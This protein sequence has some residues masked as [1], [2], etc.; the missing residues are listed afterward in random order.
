MRKSGK[1]SEARRTHAFVGWAKAKRAHHA[2]L[3]QMKMVGTAQERLYPPLYKREA[4][5]WHR[6]V[7]NGP[8]RVAAQ[9][10]PPIDR[11][12]AHRSRKGCFS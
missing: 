2:R 10:G 6:S 3:E 7:R 12:D 8:A 11:I 9:A 5:D 1:F 4:L